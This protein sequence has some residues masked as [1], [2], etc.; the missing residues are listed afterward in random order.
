MKPESSEVSA[1]LNILGQNKSNTR[2]EERRGRASFGR[3]VSN[4]TAEV[5]ECWKVWEEILLESCAQ[6]DK[7]RD[8]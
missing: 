8:E 1:E 4:V 2:G 5:K 3:P 7:M 6:V